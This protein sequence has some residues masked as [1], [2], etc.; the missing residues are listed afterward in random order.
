MQTSIEH[1]L[2]GS[3]N[4][5]I[6]KGRK[7][8]IHFSAF[9]LLV[10]YFYGVYRQY[11]ISVNGQESQNHTLLSI[12]PCVVRFGNGGLLCTKGKKKS[13]E[14]LFS[15]F[16]TV[17]FNF[18]CSVEQR[19]IQIPGCFGAC[20][21]FYPVLRLLAIHLQM[22][23]AEGYAVFSQDTP[24]SHSAIIEVYVYVYVWQQ[25]VIL[26]VFPS[27][28]QL[29]AWEG[30]KEETYMTDNIAYLSPPFLFSL[31]YGGPI[32]QGII[33]S[34]VDRYSSIVWQKRICVHLNLGLTLGKH[35]KFIYL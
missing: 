15:P 11:K 6:L 28:P 24:K 22:Q 20:D 30:D 27:I 29:F 9:L 13:T 1:Q 33:F 17:F 12:P 18:Q 35:L 14:N 3:G 23:M 4:T 19:L 32:G 5:V 21:C 25:L 7:K 16:K 34:L 2:S 10:E 31:P 26:P 8:Q